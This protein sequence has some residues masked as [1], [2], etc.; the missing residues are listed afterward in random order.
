MGWLVSLAAQTKTKL[1]LHSQDSAK[2]SAIEGDVVTGVCMLLYCIA[3]KM[4]K[5]V[6]QSLDADSAFRVHSD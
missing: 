5:Q 1:C 6:L 3:L 4:T 2:A